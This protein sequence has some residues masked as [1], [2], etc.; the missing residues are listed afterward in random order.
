VRRNFPKGCEP[1][2]KGAFDQVALVRTASVPHSTRNEFQSLP[3]R[4]DDGLDAICVPRRPRITQG[5]LRLRKRT[6]SRKDRLCAT[7]KRLI[8]AAGRRAR[9]TIRPLSEW[10]YDLS[11]TV[12]SDSFLPEYDR[13][14]PLNN[15]EN[16]DVDD[17]T[18][19]PYKGT[20]KHTSL[21]ETLRA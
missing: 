17:L 1:I 6:L 14:V 2:L 4:L 13:L 12:L 18:F 5:F 11:R 9:L 3:T 16:R 20:A 21:M 10:A 15:K 8:Q 19:E 7:V